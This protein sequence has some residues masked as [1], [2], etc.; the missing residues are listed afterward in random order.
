[1]K[2][3]DQ[4]RTE[5]EETILSSMLNSN[6]AFFQILHFG[7]DKELFSDLKCKVVFDLITDFWLSNKKHPDIFSLYKTSIG[8]DK[9]IRDFITTLNILPETL[10]YLDPVKALLDDNCRVSITNLLK[11]TEKSD[12]PGIELAFETSDK[13]NSFI[14]KYYKKY[15]PQRGNYQIAKEVLSNIKNLMEG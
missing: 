4:G 15:T 6:T 14:N 7:I 8:K 1:M 5:L 12:S 13:I 3:S 11:E 2:L 10:D 9:E